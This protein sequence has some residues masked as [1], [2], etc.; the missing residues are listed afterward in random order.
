MGSTQLPGLIDVSKTG[1]VQK[2]ASQSN[3]R[4][5]L[6]GNCLTAISRQKA[7]SDY[8][9]IMLNGNCLTATPGQKDKK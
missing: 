4:I 1:Q 2:N 9:T 5:M 8:R 7:K 6:Y 3:Y